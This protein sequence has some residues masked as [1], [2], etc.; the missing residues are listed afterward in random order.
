MGAAAGR[1]IVLRCFYRLTRATGWWQPFTIE[2]TEDQMVP[3]HLYDLQR[4]GATFML[5]LPVPADVNTPVFLAGKAEIALLFFSS[6]V[7]QDL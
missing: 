1:L 4:P 6:L 7:L 3:G 2:L 5:S